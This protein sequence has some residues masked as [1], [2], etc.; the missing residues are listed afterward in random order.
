MS[1]HSDNDRNDTGE[2]GARDER[3][4]RVPEPDPH[5][6]DPRDREPG[7]RDPRDP[8]DPGDVWAE[9][10]AETG[11]GSASGTGRRGQERETGERP[12]PF[13]ALAGEAMRLLESLQDRAAREVGRGLIR[14]ATG[15][16]GHTIRS[17][18]GQG[19][20]RR[21]VWEEAVSAPEDEEYICRACPVC[22]VIAAQREAGRASGPA[23]EG[24][25]ADHLVAAGGEL[26]AAVRQAMDALSRP[27][28]SR[29]GREPREPRED[30]RP[31]VEHIDLG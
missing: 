2:A 14:G 24:G 16:I 18:S 29:E 8:G 21:D 22:R 12:D 19:G 1:E 30:R 17:M 11:G 27:P 13:G 7:D 15:G 6:R 10:T 4:H 23:A 3:A 31:D 26:F 9:A 5:D 28:A 20:R 25:V